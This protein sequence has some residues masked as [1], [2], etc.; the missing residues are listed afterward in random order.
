LSPLEM[1]VSTAK[2][3]LGYTQSSVGLLGV[4][5]AGSIGIAA[6]FW[7]MSLGQKGILSWAVDKVGGTVVPKMEKY[8]KGGTKQAMISFNDGITNRHLLNAS[9]GGGGG[10]YYGKN[11]RRRITSKKG[12]IF[13]KS[14]RGRGIGDFA[15][16]VNL[17]NI[18]KISLDIPKTGLSKMGLSK[19]LPTAGASKGMLKSAGSFAKTGLKR[20]PY[21]GGAITTGLAGM[22][23]YDAVKEGKEGKEL[24]KTVGKEGGRVWGSG[25]GGWG[26][27]AAGAAI[28]SVV[29]PVVGTAIGAAIGGA[30][31]LWG[32]GELG[33]SIGSSLM[34]A[35]ERIANDFKDV[36]FGNAFMEILD[37]LV[38]I[39]VD[40]VKDILNFDVPDFFDWTK[41]PGAPA[42]APPE[43][44][45][46]SAP[47]RK[48][49]V[50]IAET[51][52]V[53][54]LVGQA[55]RSL[56]PNGELILKI[57]DFGGAVT[58]VDRQK[59]LIG[60]A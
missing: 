4:L 39:P 49:T 32:G 20:V 56:S 10:D 14:T 45:E 7:K 53:R 59:Q 48:K 38:A 6:A 46:A 2:E 42:K 55:S 47:S 58:D 25:L 33:E 12:K 5:V 26:G 28:G 30:L 29:V 31:G 37:I 1:L 27:A 41:T 44:K 17:K 50:N 8:V 34:D 22:S 23:I 40:I 51:N 13:Q 16:K 19:M 54:E 43:P 57:R 3:A 21:L 35:G 52:R 9:G 36:D 15:R 60:L 18:P 24:R 11:K